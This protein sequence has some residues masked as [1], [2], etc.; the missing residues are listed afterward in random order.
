M[1]EASPINHP[2]LSIVTIQYVNYPVAQQVHLS[3]YEPG[4]RALKPGVR[5]ALST[6]IGLSQA[7][8]FIVTESCIN[9]KNTM[10]VEACRAGAFHE[11]PNFL[12]INPDACGDCGRCKPPCPL[13][14]I[15]PSRTI[16]KNQ[17]QFIEINAKMSQIWPKIT[18]RVLPPPDTEEWDGVDDKLK[19]IEL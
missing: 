7:M 19:L 3:K 1:E 5:V 2:P 14:A 8:A 10:C 13:G 6:A 11:G 16:P 15:T 4:Y 17:Q 12:V 9:C 18:E